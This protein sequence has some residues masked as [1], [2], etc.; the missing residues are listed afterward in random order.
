MLDIALLF[1]SVRFLTKSL[2]KSLLKRESRISLHSR[3][4][5]TIYSKADSLLYLPSTALS[6]LYSKANPSQKTLIE[7]SSTRSF[8]TSLTTYVFEELYGVN[9][10]MYTAVKILGVSDL[11]N[12]NLLISKNRHDFCRHCWRVLY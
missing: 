12:S 4:S 5:P 7:Y 8:D 1:N 11:F 9:L 2:L 6:L 10:M 3:H